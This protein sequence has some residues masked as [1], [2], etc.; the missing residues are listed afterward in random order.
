M[1]MIKTNEELVLEARIKRLSKPKEV[2]AKQ[3]RMMGQF[4]EIYCKQ[5]EAKG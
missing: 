2:L 3:P 5:R 4:V 1:K